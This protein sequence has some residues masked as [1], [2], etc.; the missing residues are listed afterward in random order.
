MAAEAR[1]SLGAVLRA[2][3]ASDLFWSFRRTPMAVFGAVLFVVLAGT[4]VLAPVLSPQN[5]YD[6]AQIFID[7]AELPPIWAKD[8]EWPFLLGTDPQGRDVLSTILYGT[9]ISLLIGLASVLC[10]MAIGVTIGLAAGYFGGWVDNVLM[11][12]AD[13]VLSIPTLL[14][15]ILVS[16]VFKGLLPP[17]LRDAFSGVILVGAISLTGWV[18]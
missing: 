11:R 15:A 7:K 3:V 17:G 13:T 16:A 2:I 14:V 4:A 9:R 5:P 12:L 8:G 6:L 10:A 18:Q 1:R